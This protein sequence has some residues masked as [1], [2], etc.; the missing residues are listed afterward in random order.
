MDCKDKYLDLSR[1]I[2]IYMILIS[3]LI[4]GCLK[5]DNKIT[6]ETN[7]SQNHS[8]FTKPPAWASEVVWYQIFVER[9]RNGDTTN[10]P[11]A[12]DIIGTYPGFIPEGWKITPWTQDWYEPDPYFSE[13]H[14]K[15]D[16]NN[17]PVTTFGQKSQL[18]RYGGDLQGVMDMV[19]YLDSLGITA[20]Y[21]NP[22]NDAPSLHKYDAAHWR[23]IDHTF[24][25]SPRADVKQMEEETPDDPSTWTWTSADKMFLDLI[26]TLH[27]RGI[28]VIMDYSWNHT[29]HTCWA[30][31]D[32]VEKQE[33]SKYSDWY[34]IREFDDPATPENEFSYRGWFGVNSLPEI[35]ETEYIDHSDGI[36]PA[37]GDIYSEDVKEHIYAVTER[38]LDPNGDGDPSDGVDGFRLDVA[39]EVPF[40]FWRS[41]RK[42]VRSINPQAY[43]VGEVW[44]KKGPDQLLDPE[45]FLKGDIFDAPMNYRWYRAS[46]HLFGSTPDVCPVSVFVDSINAFRHNI[47]KVNNYAMMNL[48]SSHDA[49]RVLTSLYNNNMYKQNAKPE[50]DSTYKINK[51]D[52]ETYDRLKMLLMHQF[53]YIGA[54]HIWA[55][56]EMGMWGADDPSC[57]KPLIWPDYKFDSERSH[58]LGLEQNEDEVRFNKDLFQFYRSLIDLR[59]KNSVL[60][61]GEID[62]SVIDDENRILAYSRFDKSNEIVVVFNLSTVGQYVD[63]PVNHEGSYVMWPEGDE[64]FKTESGQL[65]LDVPSASGIIL[66]LNK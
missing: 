42:K 50:A 54:P 14:G 31:K 8:S 51:P 12:G 4:S 60:V 40:G 19:G 25:P 53:T 59:K 39:A 13:V 23:H 46:R 6:P 27:S 29:G 64:G 1:E 22:L 9:F 7:D 45:P 36:V 32:V 26:D 35:R 66:I 49:P 33:R 34:W 61:H 43:L 5:N 10:D 24:G 55:G 41:Y 63:I 52:R 3:F 16:E 56:D 37:E 2:Y 28:K 57:R 17:Y 65:Q 15:P 44:W 62:F 58:P 11:T 38:W 30:W 47:R 20:I 21:F 48:V 18:R